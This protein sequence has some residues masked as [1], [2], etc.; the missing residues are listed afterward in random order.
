MSRLIFNDDGS[1]FLYSWDNLT[2]DDVRAYLQRLAGT[3][4]D[5]VA[6]C[7]AFGGYVTYYDSQIAER[8][9][10]GFGVTDQVKTARVADNLHRLDDEPG[11]YIGCVFAT[12][13]DMG[14]PVVASFRMNDAHMSSD[15][16]GTVAGRFWM[17]HPEWRL[18]EPY[19]YYGSCLNYAMPEVREYLRQLVLEVIALYPDIDGI[20]LDGLRSPF[21]FPAGEGERLAPIMTDF[22][23]QIR[24]D[25]QAGGD[26]L[27]RVN[28]PR[29]PALSVQTGMDVA[30]WEAEGLVDGISPGCY[31]ADFQPDVQAWKSL[32]SRTPVQPYINC[33]PQSGQYLTLEEYRGASAN[34]WNAG[35]DGVYLFNFPCLDELSF[36]Q[37]V[38]A[39]RPSFPAP[40]FGPVGWHDSVQR[41]HAAL[42][43]VGDAEGLRHADKRFLFCVE[44]KSQYWHFAPAELWLDRLGAGSAEFVWQCY[45]DY[46]AAEKITLEL[47]LVGVSLR[48]EFAFTIN[49]HPVPQTQRLYSSS[50]RDARIH[51]LPLDPYSQYTIQVDADW[52]ASGANT[53]GIAFTQRNP[54]LLG[55]V[56]LREVA[57][58]IAY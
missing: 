10:S 13:R 45:E 4:V 54:A 23:R 39:D 11:G 49:G 6:Y 27:L 40:D 29:D 36:L 2:G 19:G 18:G 15:P 37:P 58:D 33:S 51:S 17:N 30:A 28:V 42:K 46:A 55:Q 57:L 56:Q 7:V 48:D 31:N 8:I 26:Y 44:K 9:G 41:T 25:L 22:I 14:L 38:P 43:E 21:F 34:A 20:E 3:Q 35:A 24:A 47:K 5:M 53:L 32:L 16:V 50:G 12:L 52:M 1:N